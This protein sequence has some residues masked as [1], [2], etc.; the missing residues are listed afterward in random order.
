MSLCC[1]HIGGVLLTSDSFNLHLHSL[2]A[3]VFLNVK[4]EYPHV[5]RWAEDIMKRSAVKRGL[6]VN[7]TWGEEGQLR[8]R[9]D[10]KDFDNFDFTKD[11]PTKK[12]GD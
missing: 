7:K 3:E 6:I 2:D 11:A 1:L 10:A 8:E 12:F 5:I 9:H 4:E